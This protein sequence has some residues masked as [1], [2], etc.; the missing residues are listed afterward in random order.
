MVNLGN[1]VELKAGEKHVVY[2]V[3]GSVEADPLGGKISNESPIGEAIFGKKVGD[4]VIVN[5]IKGGVRYEILSI[6]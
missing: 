4:E 2:T 3:V 1:E 5:T 6:N